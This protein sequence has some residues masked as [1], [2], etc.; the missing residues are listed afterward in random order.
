M[1]YNEIKILLRKYLDGDTTLKE[2]QLLQDY[3]QNNEDIPQEFTYAKTMFNQFKQAKTVSYSQKT[4]HKTLPILRLTAIAV[5]IA[6]LAGIGIHQMVPQQKTIYGY[7]DGK[8]I[9]DKTVAI[10]EIENAFDQISQNLNRG[11]KNLNQLSKF[12]KTKQL[13]MGNE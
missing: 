2:E 5:S 6:L 7:I 9:T 11:T 1:D 4:K 10:N 13:I 12:Y 3:F 8:P